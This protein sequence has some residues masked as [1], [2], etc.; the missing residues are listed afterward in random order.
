MTKLDEIRARWAKATPG[1][2]EIEREEDDVV[3]HAIS[4]CDLGYPSTIGPLQDVVYRSMD[5]EQVEADAEAIAHAPE[6]IAFLLAE[7]E[8]LQKL[9]PLPASEGLLPHE[10]REHG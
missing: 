1:P 10:D 2:W 5:V 9:V 3:T 7:V 6:D 4:P 8:R